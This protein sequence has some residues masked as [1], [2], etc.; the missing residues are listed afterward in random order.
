MNCLEHGLLEIAFSIRLH[1]FYL[2][3]F[4][5]F[6]SQKTRVGEAQLRVARPLATIKTMQKLI[7]IL[8]GLLT[9]HILEAQ[10]WN[11][12]VT[13]TNENLNKIHFTNDTTGFITGDNGLLLKTLDG[14]NTWDTVATNVQHNLMTISFANED[15]GYINGLKTIDGGST[16]LPQVSSDIYGFMYSYD[17]NRIMAGHGSSF[18]GTIYESN[19]G[20]LSWLLHWGF[21]GLGMFNDCDFFNQNEG[22]ISSWYAGHLF[23]TA[24]AGANWSEIVIDEVDGNSWISDDYMSVAFPSQDTVLVTHESGILKTV[25]GG[26][27]WSEIKP[28]GAISNFYPTSVIV[29]A[30][31]NYLLVGRGN[32]PALASPR[33]YETSDGGVN[34]TASANTVEQIRDVACNTSYCFAVGSNGTVYRK[35]NLINSLLENI[36]KGELS[37]FPNP[38]KDILQIAYPKEITEVRIYDEVGRLHHHNSN[39]HELIRTSH[40]KPGLYAIQILCSDGE[41]AT[42]KFIKE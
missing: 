8:F 13:G 33:I 11:V 29:L 6:Q 19:D 28:A 9:S 4:C 20:G 7:L 39:N 31:D 27:T 34:W 1:F 15:V 10:S 36:E 32:N 35:E 12:F 2:K 30:T 37:I 40:L 25:D 22:Y 5:N 3:D 14:G 24:D 16:W 21:G 42:S 26:S 41:I 18:D 23:K 17:E 38:T